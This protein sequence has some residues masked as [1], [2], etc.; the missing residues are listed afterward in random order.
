[1]GKDR[2][3]PRGLHVKGDRSCSRQAE[4]EGSGINNLPR[5]LFCGQSL[6][7]LRPT[8]SRLGQ[9]L[10]VGSEMRGPKL[11]LSLPLVRASSRPGRPEVLLESS[12]ALTCEL[13]GPDLQ[14]GSLTG[15]GPAL[16]LPWA[17]PSGGGRICREAG[18]HQFPFHPNL[19]SS[20]GGVGQPLQDPGESAPLLR[21]DGRHSRPGS[22]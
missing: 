8:E 19:Q 16:I 14:G 17:P 15:G 9:R 7:D 18:T 1:M 22:N 2:C 6:G 4:T 10:W 13:P 11:S 12:P 20:V 3:Q 5:P 21:W